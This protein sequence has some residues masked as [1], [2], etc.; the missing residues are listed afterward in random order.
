MVHSKREILEQYSTFLERNIVLTDDLL[1]W[2]K[3]EKMLTNR[4][5]TDIQA[6]SSSIEKNR[7]F[8]SNI[9]DYGDAGFTKL[10]EGLIANG[11]PFIGELLE[12][13]DK[14]ASESADDD[15]SKKVKI[16]D[17]MLKQCPGVDKLRADT[18]DK[19]KTYLQEQLFRAYIRD[20][21]SNQNQGKSV[22]MINLK[23]QHY[24]KQRR[25]S[26]SVEGD[27]QIIMN[28]REALRDAQIAR[29]EKEDEVRDLRNEIARLKVDIEQ[30][31]S[32]QIKMVDANTRTVFKMHDKMV[33][34]ADWL[35]SLGIQSRYSLERQTEIYLD[36][37]LGT[38][39]NGSGIDSDTLDQLENKLKRYR[40]EIESLRK[41]G[42]GTDK[43]KEELYN[44]IYS[45]RSLSIEDR[46]N[47]SFYELLL[48]LYGLN[49]VTELAKICVKDVLQLKQDRDYVHD[50]KWRDEK[51]DRLTRENEELTIENEQ[52][53]STIDSTKK[54][55]WRPA[56]SSN[57][58]E[59]RD[60]GRQRD[61]LKPANVQLGAK[62]GSN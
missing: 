11:Q 13:E 14:K 22:E 18:R 26:I 1:L 7:I 62:P 38:N 46:N 33:M 53:R 42:I 29:Q 21:W 49:Q 24:E 48:R 30:K 20:K 56:N 27:K 23:R 37:I 55:P 8:L 59:K 34:L 2:I 43:L 58:I 57:P 45:S 15:I 28:L 31:W 9:S 19:L 60:L 61:V 32:S 40:S 51:I 12:N 5:L 39:I 3:D 6:I 35:S 17:E 54:A 4:V 25:L 44:A 36:E 52:L 16:D 50:V 10:V 47:K 41:R